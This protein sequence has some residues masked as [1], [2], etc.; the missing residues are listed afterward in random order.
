MERLCFLWIVL[1]FFLSFW[2]GLPM[3]AL[4][5]LCGDF[6][7][8]FT[9]F[10][11][12]GVAFFLLAQLAYLCNLRQLAFPWPAILLLPLALLLPLVFLG[13]LYGLLF[14]CHFLLA[15]K[16][17]KAQPSLYRKLYLLGLVLFICCDLLVA[18][19]YFF[20]AH[21]RWIWGFYAP[22]Q[23]LLALTARIMPKG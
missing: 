7:L 11:G 22:S 10:Y 12:T 13:G 1:C 20:T 5:T 4:F 19:G 16:I 2:R 17:E 23:L 18:W 21:P 14:F 3:A 9:G 8:L 6:F 15:W